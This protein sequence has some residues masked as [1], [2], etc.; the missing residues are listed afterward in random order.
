MEPEN[1]R[2]P[3][4]PTGGGDSGTRQAI[5]DAARE[6][7]AAKGYDGA[8]LRVIAA[9]AGVDTG[10]IRHFY[11]SK[12]DLFDAALE[13]PQEFTQRV[14]RAVTGDPDNFGERLV[15]TYLTL[16]EDPASSAALLAIVRSAIVSDRAADRLQ[17]VLNARFL[18][19]LA[20][21][22]GGK[23]GHARAALAGAHLLG[24]AIARYVV[25]AGPI[26]DLDRGT[27]VAWCAPAVQRYLTAPLG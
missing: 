21:H 5:L 25:R 15:D 24:I 3:G 18:A 2:T 13:I 12:D 26:A 11:G 4:R 14:A 7:F 27:L 22:L 20:P 16:W 6:Q 19:E 23:G 17:A 9:A 1:R 8:S 10:L